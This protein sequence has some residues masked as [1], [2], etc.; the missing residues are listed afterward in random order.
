[1]DQYYCWSWRDPPCWT[2]C[3]S[4]LW[5]KLVQ[6]RPQSSLD[7]W[8]KVSLSH[9]L[10]SSSKPSKYEHSEMIWTWTMLEFCLDHWSETVISNLARQKRTFEHLIATLAEIPEAKCT[11]YK[12]RSRSLLA[13]YAISNLVSIDKLQLIRSYQAQVGMICLELYRHKIQTAPRNLILICL[14]RVWRALCLPRSCQA[15]RPQFCLTE[16]PTFPVPSFSPTP[17]LPRLF[18]TN[19]GFFNELCLWNQS[20]IF[21]NENHQ[22]IS[23]RSLS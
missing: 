15:S 4:S 9:L 16:S 13:R 12:A 22:S 3:L 21:L 17:R 18:P 20:S 11:N 7:P 19:S 14:D 5:I 6:T 8:T 23:A 2:T 10:N 1:M